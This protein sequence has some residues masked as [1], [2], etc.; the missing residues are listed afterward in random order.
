MI[1]L[2]D[3]DDDDIDFNVVTFYFVRNDET[4]ETALYKRSA[5]YT[6]PESINLQ[7]NT[8]Q[9]FAIAEVDSSEIILSSFEL[10]LDEDSDE[11]FFVVEDDKDAP[12]GFRV[13]VVKQ[14]EDE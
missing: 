7:N 11:L 6:Q 5:V 8:Y 2:V 12:T 3:D 14:T 13:E 1:N 4:I 9:V 10:V